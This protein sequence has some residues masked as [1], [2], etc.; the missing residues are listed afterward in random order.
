MSGEPEVLIVGAGPTGL[1][2]AWRL[3]EL[4][5]TAWRVVEATDAP[6]GLAASVVDENGFTWDLGGHVTFSHYDTFD[7]ALDDLLG[8]AWVEHVRESWIR[9]RDRFIPYPFQNNLW[10]LPPEDLL[11]CLDGLLEVH[12]GKGQSAVPA[13][14]RDWVFGTFG[15][16]LAEVFFLPYNWKVWAH[17]PSELSV[18]WMGERVA[19]VDLSRVLHSLVLRRDDVAWGPN[20]RFRFPLDG[21]TGAIWSTLCSRLPEDKVEFGRK[22]VE[23]AAEERTAVFSDGSEARYDRLISSTPLDSLLRSMTGAAEFGPSADQLKFSSSHIVGIGVDGEL[24]E[25]LAVKNWIY[26]PEPQ[27][28]FYRVTVFSNYSPNN[29]PQPGRQWSLLCEVSESPQKPVDGARVV[30][31]VI[32]GLREAGMLPEDSK[33]LS[34]WHRRLAHGYPTPFVG[35]D[36]LLAEIEPMLREL[37]IW[38]RG[39]FGAWKYEVSN[40]DH[41]F[42]QGVEAVDNIVSGA[43][44]VTCFQPAVVNEVKRKT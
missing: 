4:G 8:N 16:G 6:G 31:E 1:G 41:S 30:D 25:A 32:A 34:R 12:G 43:E 26:F 42:M 44:E 37:S 24:P 33:L 36:E 40:Q 20:S 38:S 7:R 39:R 35:R 11:P 27:F 13:N 10:R 19:T 23:L 3:Q 14:L 29:V 2:A 21:G 9:M 17:D 5:Y 15:K 18:G 22:V 28:P